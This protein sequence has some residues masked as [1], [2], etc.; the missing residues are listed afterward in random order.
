MAK[1]AKKSKNPSKIEKQSLANKIKSLWMNLNSRRL[2]YLK[3]RP[4]RSFKRTRRRDYK[5]SLKLPGYIA[6]TTT[7]LKMIWA[8]RWQYFGLM[9]IYIVLI[10][11]LSA[12]MTQDSYSQIK[13]LVDET[14][15]ESFLNGI[16][17]L[18]VLFWNIVVG[19]ITTVSSAP[20]SSQQIAVILLSLYAWLAIIWLTRVVMAGKRPRI[21]DSLYNSG[22]PVIALLLLVVVMMI[23]ALPGA[24]AVILYSAADQ[25]GLLSQTVILMLAGGAMV[26]IVTLSLY[27][28]TSTFFAMI[29]VTLPGMYPM[30]ALRL[31]GD[32]VVGRRMRILLR[33]LWILLVI[34]LI[35]VVVLVPTILLD[36][37]LKSAIPAID[38]LPIVPVVALVLSIFSLVI[39]TVY[40]YIFYRKVVDDDSA[41]A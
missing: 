31:A 25:S 18:A 13:E 21:R 39:F 28:M 6:L 9:L 20:N 24:I 10:I 11:A 12:M 38:W 27:W 5:R 22:S 16:I 19:Q 32:L 33:L 37:A 2:A 8:N 7:A 3:R 29:I 15:D 4:H 36:G 34:L 41:P 14:R 17:A 1:S 26:S 23:Q 30:E 35:W 40:I